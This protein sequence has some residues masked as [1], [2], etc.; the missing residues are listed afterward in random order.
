MSVWRRKADGRPYAD[1]R[2]V[3][4]GKRSLLNKAIIREHG[5]VPPDE[6]C[7]RVFDELMA[8][9]GP[10]LTGQSVSRDYDIPALVKWY[11]HTYKATAPDGTQNA[12]K[13]HLMR[14]EEWCTKR[15][16]AFPD[17]FDT[18]IAQE[19]AK[20]LMAECTPGSAKTYMM[21]VRGLFTA[22]VRTGLMRKNPVTKWPS[23][24]RT[25]PKVKHYTGEQLREVLAA[26]ETYQPDYA[27]IITFLAATGWGVG[28]AA[29]LEWSNIDKARRVANRRRGKTKTPMLLPLNQTAMESIERAR[30]FTGLV[31]PGK[32]GKR[33]HPHA[34]YDALR[35]AKDS[36]GIKYDCTLHMFRHTVAIE[37][38]R[39][40]APLVIVAQVLGNN[41]ETVLRYYQV[42]APG[43]GAPFMDGWDKELRGNIEVC[44]PN[45]T[46][47]HQAL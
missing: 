11:V 38:T 33:V 37:L 20:E 47:F 27:P 15:K 36:A 39:S 16:I 35:R 6:V 43:S 10:T 30:T 14:W 29:A 28:D 5:A 44:H 21:A 13:Y 24:P 23:F 17:S 40:G 18:V 12:A 22:A 26:V 7:Q 45:V 41:I 25:T 3:G 42:F 4:L 31:F 9:L 2:D 19:Y 8:E 1:L 34:V 46:P 32:G